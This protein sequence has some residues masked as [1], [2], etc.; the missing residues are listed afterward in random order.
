MLRTYISAKQNGSQ[1]RDFQLLSV[2]EFNASVGSLVESFS[3]A[4]LDRA[5]DL[6][7]ELYTDLLQDI[8]CI[9]MYFGSCAVFVPCSM[10][11]DLLP[12]CAE[13]GYVHSCGLS[14]LNRNLTKATQKEVFERLTAHLKRRAISKARLVVYAHEDFTRHDRRFAGELK[15]GLDDVK[16]HAEKYYIGKD[17]LVQTLKDLSADPHLGSRLDIVEPAH[18]EKG[19]SLGDLPVIWLLV[20]HRPAGEIR[21]RSDEQYYILYEQQYRNENVFHL[22]DENKPAW[23][24]HTTIPHHSCPK[25]AFSRN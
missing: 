16:L 13:S 3:E 17:S 12:V 1:V 19:G 15:D 14:V 10:E 21:T 5:L 8:V 11:L 6:V 2:Q 20:D 25:Q 18:Y 4:G 9:Q 22:F 7:A 23:N 24:D